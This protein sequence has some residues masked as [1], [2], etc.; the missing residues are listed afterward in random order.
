MNEKEIDAYLKDMCVGKNVTYE[1]IIEIVMILD[2]PY[3]I[4]ERP[5]LI[6]RDFIF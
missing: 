1:A 5:R 4:W 3:K 2:W 6:I